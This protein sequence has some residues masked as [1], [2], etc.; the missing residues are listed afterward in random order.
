MLFLL[1]FTNDKIRKGTLLNQQTQS[2][3]VIILVIVTDYKNKSPSL[4]R[5]YYNNNDLCRLGEVIITKPVI[6]L[7]VLRLA[8]QY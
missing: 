5:L 3:F 8:E 7:F 2:T 1:K 4:T 6:L